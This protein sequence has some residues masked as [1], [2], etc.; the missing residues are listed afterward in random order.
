MMAAMEAVQKGTSINKA[1]KLHGVP[2]TTLKDRLSGRVTHGVKPGPKPYLDPKEE[3]ALA[4]HLVKSANVGYAKTRKEVKA[5]VGNV[6][7]EKLI[8]RSRVVTDGWWRRFKARQPQLALRRGDATAQVRME[9]TNRVA[10][11]EYF[12][13]LESTLQQYNLADS[14]AQIYNMDETGMPL[15][16]RPPSVI[17][18]RGQKKVRSRV[19]GRKEQITVIGCGN[20]VGQSIPPM[21]IFEGKYL[22][23]Q[24]TVGEVSGT[25]YGMSGKG[26]T[27]QEL[28]M[29]WLKEHF[30]KYAVPGRPLL[31]LLDGHS[32]HYEPASMELAREED[33][34]VFCLPPHTTQDSQPLDCTVFG[35]LKHHWSEAC[36]TFLQ[37]NPGMIISRLN[38]SS[39]FSGAWLKAFTPENVLAGFRKCGIYPFNRHAIPLSHDKGDDTP[40]TTTAAAVELSANLSTSTASNQSISA[41]V[42]PRTPSPSGATA[43]DIN[44]SIPTSFTD[45]QDALFEHRFEEGYDIY[46]DQQYV[47]WLR[48][49]HPQSIAA[50]HVH[51]ITTSYQP[52][53]LLDA[54]ADITPLAPVLPM[55]SAISPFN[56]SSP[57]L[58]DSSGQTGLSSPG[59]DVTPS[60]SFSP[61]LSVPPPDSSSTPANTSGALSSCR[62]AVV[63]DPSQ[64]VSPMM[65]YLQ[66]PTAVQVKPSAASAKTRA[67]T[68]AR[69]LTSATCLAIIK[70]KEMK[71]QRE[72][73]EKEERKKRRE[74]KKR[75]REDEKRK[76]AEERA[77][78]AKEKIRK[79]KE[80]EQ[81]A[82]KAMEQSRKRADLELQS[83][84]QS[85]NRDTDPAQSSTAQHPRGKRCSAAKRA[86]L[87]D[88]ISSDSCCV[89]F[90]AFAE[91]V[92]EGTGAE[93]VQCTCTRWLHED[94]ILD[95]IID[96]SGK[97]RLC[98]FC[99]M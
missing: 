16:H 25:Y 87:E 22:N 94:C 1:A 79:A 82:H 51:L 3:H 37:K 63:P 92:E 74:E 15:D 29:H 53:S 93:W 75:Q 85:T 8:I 58:T 13:L 48:L 67:V 50:H 80:R 41:A 98:P 76:K 36:H 5:I 7:R 89:C 52:E 21:V 4:D 68:G 47:S 19:S 33:V 88:N 66:I 28:F 78:K 96:S 31:L 65:K 61:V 90:Q 72:M 95:S 99:T 24:W 64:E 84:S 57:D 91:D 30:L 44:K 9:S 59:T 26:W 86:R 45:E 32:S 62:S 69:V 40:S 56:L 70:E 81:R 38:F 12:N 10:I 60:S 71:K 77:L 35:P 54:F 27:D 2:C 46:S 97:E 17:A 34:I 73:E 39:I 14:P 55:G 20:A 11:E 83:C 42:E 6:V 43:C 49:H 23:H 18:K